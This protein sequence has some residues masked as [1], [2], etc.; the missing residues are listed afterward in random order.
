MNVHDKLV[1]LVAEMEEQIERLPEGEDKDAAVKNFEKLYRLLLEYE[2]LNES[3]TDRRDKMKMDRETE[4]SKLKN[5]KSRRW[6]E[7]VTVLL[8]LAGI[9]GSQVFSIV[10]SNCGFF[11]ERVP[12]VLTRILFKNA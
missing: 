8:A 2:T 12:N 7:L 10:A 4:Q 5:E 9:L 3:V 6:H 11:V 1:D